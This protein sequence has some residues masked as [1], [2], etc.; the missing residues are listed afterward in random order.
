[1]E[2]ILDK[3]QVEEIIPQRDPI[4][5]I[6]G[7]G[8]LIPGGRVEAC[9]HVPEDMD[10]FRGHFPGDPML[11]GVYSVEAMAQAADILLLTLERYRGKAPLFLGIGRT[12]FRR[13]IRPGDDLVIRAELVSERVEK[14]VATC[15]AAI[16]VDGALA[17]EG[18][19]TLAMR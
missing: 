9:F 5:L 12:S 1:M 15:S 11:P 19:V 18:E 2:L 10:V 13:P 8:E 16:H 3:K 7:V 6:D 4:L 17:A 14:A